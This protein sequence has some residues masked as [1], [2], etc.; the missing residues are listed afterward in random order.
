MRRGE[1]RAGDGE[2]PQRVHCSVD[3]ARGRAGWCCAS[4]ARRAIVRGCRPSSTAAATRRSRPSARRSRPGS[5]SA[6]S[7]ARR[8]PCGSD[9]RLVVDLWAGLADPP[10]AGRGRRTRSRT[11]TRSRSRSPPR[12]LWLLVERGLARARRAGRPLL[13]RVRPAGKEATLVRHVLAQ[14]SGLVALRE[15]QPAEALL[16]WERLVALLAAEPPLFEPGTRHGGAGALPRPPGRRARP[17]RRRPHARALLRR[18]G[19]GAVGARLP[20][21]PRRRRAG[22]LRAAR[23]RGRRLAA[24]AATTI[25]GRCSSPRSTTRPARSTRTS[26]TRP[27]TAPPRCPPSTATAPRARS[28]RSTA[29]SRREACSTACGCSRRR[30]W[31]R[32]CTRGRSARTCCSSRR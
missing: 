2:A 11:P 9:G 5:T 25:R 23:R 15:P 4:F 28:R 31:T 14:Q 6:A 10:P 24:V 22:A 21:R 19:R 17:P 20:L 18:G 29:G 26:S 1:R 8:S 27:P 3:G 13:A 12:A 7:S 16:D 30:R 32:R